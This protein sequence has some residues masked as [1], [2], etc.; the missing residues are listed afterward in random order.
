MKCKILAS[1]AIGLLGGSTA[2]TSQV[3]DGTFSGELYAAQGTQDG[4]NLA[5]L[6]GQPITGT[7]SFNAR[8]LPLT[9]GGA[10]MAF[11][12]FVANDALHPLA[13]S[14]TVDGDTFTVDGTS[15]STLVTSS[16]AGS[17]YFYLGANSGP[18]DQ[19]NLGLTN[20]V[21]TPFLLNGNKAGSTRFTF[22][23]PASSE[24][25]VGQADFNDANTGPGSEAVLEFSITNAAAERKHRMQA[26]E[27][28]PSSAASGL[29]LLLG[30]L[31][32]LWGRRTSRYY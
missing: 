10:G 16:G 28:D 3:V 27:I 7:F 11:S 12:D 23:A 2:A 20:D 1:I 13:I 14:V 26:P 31:V 30:S 17:T 4:V 15:V 8:S 25:G 29:T 9:S 24:L 32:V 22:S 18:H 6:V 5:S 19:L 21:G